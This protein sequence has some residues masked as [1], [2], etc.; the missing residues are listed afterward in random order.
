M[1]GDV[2]TRRPFRA[3]DIPAADHDR[4]GHSVFN[5]ALSLVSPVLWAGESSP[6]LDIADGLVTARGYTVVVTRGTISPASSSRVSVSLESTCM[7][8]YCAPTSTNDW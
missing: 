4:H 8:K 7:M 1:D 5:L 3:E 2:D 6:T